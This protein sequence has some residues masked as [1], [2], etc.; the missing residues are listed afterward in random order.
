[1]D[2]IKVL[3]RHILLEYNDLRDS[4]FVAWIKIMALTASLEH[5]PTRE[6][7]LK[8]THYKTLDSLQEKLNR[9]SIDLQYVLNK[10]LIDA[11]EVSNRRERW[12]DK[13]KKQRG[14]IETVPGD[15]P[16]DVPG[17]EK[18]REEKEKERKEK[19]VTLSDDEWLKTLEDNPIYEG[20]EV[21]VLYGK[22][23]VW[24]NERGKKATRRRFVNWL[25]REDKPIK[26]VTGATGTR[27]PQRLPTPEEELA[28]FNARW[29]AEHIKEARNV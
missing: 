26:P 5:E 11:Q 7:M 19:K 10:V 24:C 27:K 28:E 22:M 12:K 18:R 8:Y 15:V 17:K 20:L 2:W 16:G 25:N 29:D 3:N 14:V 13:K 4:E 9:H 23:I 21:R 1:M 6:Q